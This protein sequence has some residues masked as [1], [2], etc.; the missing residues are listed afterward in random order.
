MKVTDLR[1]DLIKVY[2]QLRSNEIGMSE[3]KG[4]ANVAGKILS[5]GKSQMEYNKM[6][7]SKNRINFFEDGE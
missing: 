3:A 6:V 7:G 1:D 5:T 4:L 2:D